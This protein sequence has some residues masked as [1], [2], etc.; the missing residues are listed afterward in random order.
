MTDKRPV[1]VF[2][3]AGG[4]IS[5]ENPY[6]YSPSWLHPNFIQ[7]LHDK[8]EAGWAAGGRRFMLHLPAGR[9]FEG[10]MASSQYW[11][12]P[13]VRRST[14]MAWVA[15]FHA[16]HPEGELIVYAG[17]DLADPYSLDM[18]DARIPDVGNFDDWL[19][20]QAN[21]NVWFANGLR[22]LWFDYSSTKLRA[23]ALLAW[24]SAL[25]MVKLGGEGVFSVRDKATGIWSPNREL[26][27]QIRSMA[28]MDFFEARD[29]DKVWTFGADEEVG[30]LMRNAE[31][32]QAE[33]LIDYHARGFTLMVSSHA[34]LVTA[35]S[36]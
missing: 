1:L 19:D 35:L 30:A 24:Q 10:R 26:T 25:P 8:V 4:I 22:S 32:E 17:F 27:H 28:R 36:L 11:T 18:T 16:A 31:D 21:W 3:C 29:P 6:G 15:Q 9:W 13:E 23:P 12:M 5:P 14:L 20:W 33:N 34:A 7:I 2:R